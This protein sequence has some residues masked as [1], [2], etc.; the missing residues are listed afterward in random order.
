MFII[1]IVSVQQATLGTQYVTTQH[2]IIQI[3]SNDM[4][5]LYKAAISRPYIP[6]PEIQACLWL[7]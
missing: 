4:F 5:L 6:F 1:P 7:P 2:F 3:Q